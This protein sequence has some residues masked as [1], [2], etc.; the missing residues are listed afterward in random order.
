MIK[1]LFSGVL[2]TLAATA[3]ATEVVRSET[4][5]PAAKTKPAAIK[6]AM[7]AP[8]QHQPLASVVLSPE[9]LIIADKVLIG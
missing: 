8:V 4:A 9:Q 3:Y 5:K 2:L 6:V 7:H 1:Q